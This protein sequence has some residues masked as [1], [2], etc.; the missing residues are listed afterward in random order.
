[1]RSA[2]QAFLEINFATSL[3]TGIV[4]VGYKNQVSLHNAFAF[5][6]SIY[7]LEIFYALV[8]SVPASIFSMYLKTKENLDVYD[9]GVSYNPFRFN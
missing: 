2:E 9:N 7:L 3:A 4:L 1:L 8:L 6:I 5:F